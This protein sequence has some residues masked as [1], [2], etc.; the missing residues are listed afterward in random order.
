MFNVIP[1]KIDVIQTK[2]NNN[3]GYSFISGDIW[4]GSIQECI[5]GKSEIILTL[6]PSFSVQILLQTL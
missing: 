2:P 3:G 5:I 6:A 4:E 1:N